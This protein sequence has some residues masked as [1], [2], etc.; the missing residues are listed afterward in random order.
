MNLNQVPMKIGISVEIV[1]NLKKQLLLP[2]KVV[3]LQA[4]TIIN[5][6]GRLEVIIL[7][8]VIVMLKFS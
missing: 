6:L 4:N 3:A 2:G 7:R 5:F 1:V 8:V